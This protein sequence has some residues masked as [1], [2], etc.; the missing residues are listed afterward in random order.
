M[1]ARLGHVQRDEHGRDDGRRR[2]RR[3]RQLQ[4]ARSPAALPSTSQ[5]AVRFTGAAAAASTNNAADYAL[6][7]AQY[8]FTNNAGA[9][10]T[11]PVELMEFKVQ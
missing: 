8:V 3:G 7:T 4:P 9:T 2:Q 6:T 11:L 1:G 5:V 10:G